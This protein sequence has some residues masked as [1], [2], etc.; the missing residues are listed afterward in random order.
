MFDKVPGLV[1]C[2]VGTQPFWLDLCK[3]CNPSSVLDAIG[4]QMETVLI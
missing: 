1:L 3:I 4:H 2:T